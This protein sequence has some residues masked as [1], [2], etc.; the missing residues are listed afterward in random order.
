MLVTMTQTTATA[1]IALG[2]S[3]MALYDTHAALSYY[4]QA[5]DESPTMEARQKLANCL[6][7]RCDYRQ[8]VTL[9]GGLPTDSMPHDVIR[10]LFFCHAYLK[11]DKQLI[12]CGQQL[13]QRFPMDAEVLARLCTVLCDKD[14]MAEA[15]EYAQRYYQRDS[16]NLLINRTLANSLYL[17]RQYAD[18]ITQYERLMAVGDTTF[19]S[20]YSVGMAYNYLENNEQAY[21][22]LLMAFKKNSKSPGCSYRL[23]M[24]CVDLQRYEEAHQY[25]TQA[26]YLLKPDN[27]IMK[28]IC[29]HQA[30]AYYGQKEYLWAA[31][32]WKK[33]R[34]YDGT[35]LAFLFNIGSCYAALYETASV[36]GTINGHPADAPKLLEMALSYYDMFIEMA[37]D[38][39]IDLDE[40]TKQM[41]TDAQAYIE[42]HQK[43]DN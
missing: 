36:E 13:L 5:Y 15:V 10:Q 12:D 14:R 37:T 39:G 11:N 41:I 24:V 20:L 40:E 22:Y 32:K 33:A 34:E 6:Y 7:Q 31:E 30:K 17:N 1:Q 3:C 2:D 43:G 8:C 27:I 29:D 35:S 21:N 38:N 9:L 28:L 4:Q 18:A 16:T 23:G 19:L 26:E 25:L 42:R